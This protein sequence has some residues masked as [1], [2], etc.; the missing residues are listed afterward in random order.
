MIGHGNYPLPFCALAKTTI[1]LHVHSKH[2]LHA[3]SAAQ[4]NSEQTKLILM[5][6]PKEAGLVYGTQQKKKKEAAKEE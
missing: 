4:T 6:Q 2:F 1:I 3:H 5:T